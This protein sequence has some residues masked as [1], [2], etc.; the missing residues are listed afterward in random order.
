[1]CGGHQQWL[2]STRRPVHPGDAAGQPPALPSVACWLMVWE[3]L[4][5]GVGGFPEE[6]T[7]EQKGTQE[8]GQTVG[9]SIPGRGNSMCKGPAA[10][11][12][13]TGG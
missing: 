9:K 2:L 4:I 12:S 3:L 1:M 10:G 6:V 7:L 11:R 13:V 8:T 5:W